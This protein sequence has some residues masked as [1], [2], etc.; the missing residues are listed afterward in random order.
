M[1]LL[2]LPI[3]LLLLVF[4][5][6]FWFIAFFNVYALIKSLIS[7]PES[8]NDFLLRYLRSWSDLWYTISRKKK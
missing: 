6:V 7:R 3:W 8:L 4:L 2:L 5:L 1:T